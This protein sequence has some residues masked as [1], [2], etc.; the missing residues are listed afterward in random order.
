MEHVLD[1]ATRRRLDQAWD[2]LLSSFEYYN[3]FLPSQSDKY[4]SGSPEKKSIADLTAAEIDA[5]PAE[6]QKYVRTFRASYDAV[7]KAE[8]SARPGHVEDCLRFAAKAWRRP[9]TETEKDRLRSFYVK[10]TESGK[11]DHGKAIEALLARVL[12]S[13]AFLYRLEQ[14]AQES[15]LKPLSDWEIASRLSY[16]LWSSMPDEEL[17]RAAGR[18]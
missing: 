15:N 3:V 2:D 6:P 13:P 12:I 1:D 17:R 5:L 4:H 10:A 11:L 9:L 7:Q 14:P 18:E 16:F 8:I